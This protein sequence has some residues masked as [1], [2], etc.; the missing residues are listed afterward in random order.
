MAWKYY[1]LAFTSKSAADD[2]LSAYPEYDGWQ[3]D[4]AYKVN[5][6]LETDLPTSLVPYI[7][8]FE[9]VPERVYFDHTREVM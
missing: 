5:L 9:M 8:P 4:S 1:S 7:R 2:S 6:P 3:S